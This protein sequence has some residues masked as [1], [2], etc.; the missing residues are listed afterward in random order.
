MDQSFS[1]FLLFAVA[2]ASA[3]L[4]ALWMGLVLWTFRDMR[5]R[6]RDTFAQG[7]A[8]LMVAV[9]NIFGLLIYLLLRPRETLAEA[10]ERSLEEEA[11]LQ[12]IEEKPV[13]PG[14]GRPAEARWQVCPH[15]HTRL[16]KQCAVCGEMLDLPWTLCPYCATPQAVEGDPA[17]RGRRSTVVQSVSQTAPRA[18]S[19]RQNETQNETDV[20]LEFV[21]SDEF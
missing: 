2:A 17:A 9:L 8:A 11:L 5:G 1:Q 4:A 12:G 13:C 7:A 15:C 18:A 21:D 3:V 19:N 14:C 16:K 20:P 10:Y 6:S